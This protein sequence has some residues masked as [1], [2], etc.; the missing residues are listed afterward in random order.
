M[1]NEKGR[2]GLGSQGEHILALFENTVILALWAAPATP[3]TL[4]SMDRE[5]LSQSVREG[6]VGGSRGER[7]G[8]K[9]N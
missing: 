4:K 8:N 3:A 1:A 7:T 6:S 9:Q 5:M 2:A